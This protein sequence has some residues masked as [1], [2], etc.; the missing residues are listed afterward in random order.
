M[1]VI[2]ADDPAIGPRSIGAI[3]RRKGRHVEG[4]VSVDNRPHGAAAE[5]LADEI[6][7]RVIGTVDR[8]EHVARLDGAAIADDRA[9]RRIGGIMER[10]EAARGSPA[11]GRGAEIRKGC[12]T[13][14]G[15]LDLAQSFHY[16]LSTLFFSTAYCRL[17]SSSP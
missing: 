12:K 4:D 10:C 6:L 17:L 1:R 15:W 3:S 9:N 2:D 5:R 11:T 8:P 7:A 16:F 13:A 14:R